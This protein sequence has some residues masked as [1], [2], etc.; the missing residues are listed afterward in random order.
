MA[1]ETVIINVLLSKFMLENST[2]KLLYRAKRIA[3]S[4]GSV[5]VF[6][7]INKSQ[8]EQIRMILLSDN[9]TKVNVII[10]LNEISNP[11]AINIAKWCAIQHTYTHN[12]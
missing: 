6:L 7:E 3:V 10:L 9:Y 4:F 11:K 1:L 12:R 5:F 8:G 2:H